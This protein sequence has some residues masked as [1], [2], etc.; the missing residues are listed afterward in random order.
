M[1]TTT[2][3]KRRSAKDA[4]RNEAS[5]SANKA[6]THVATSEKKR[7]ANGDNNALPSVVE[8][9]EDIGQAEAP[10]PL[11]V[12]DY[13]AEIRGVTAKTSQN[14]NP[15]ASV[16]FFIA[17]DQYPADYTEGEPDGTVLTFNRVSLQN[18]PASRHRLRKFLEAIGA[19]TG[20]KIDLNEWVGR[21]ATVTVQ[22]DTYEGEQRAA[23]A[24]VNA[25]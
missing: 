19:P 24:K 6:S 20:K 3:S 15:Y 22:H 1:T 9:D 25:A 21:S 14:G 11:P 12:G 16:Q 13:Q 2:K 4:S 17:A 18:T 8:F 10:V 23:I 5:A 7:M